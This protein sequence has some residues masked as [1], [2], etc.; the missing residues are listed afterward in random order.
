MMTMRGIPG[1]KTGYKDYTLDPEN[2]PEPVPPKL[3]VRKVLYSTFL[4]KI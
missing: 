3:V 2:A 4:H 1:V